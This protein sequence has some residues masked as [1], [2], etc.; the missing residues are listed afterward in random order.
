MQDSYGA[1]LSYSIMPERAAASG[2]PDPRAAA[3]VAGKFQR[4]RFSFTGYFRRSRYSIPMTFVPDTATF[5]SS[6]K[7]LS[8]SFLTMSSS[9]S[10]YSGP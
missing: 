8:I 3:I 4:S 5:L 10:S 2:I 7:Y 1:A 6:P 9:F